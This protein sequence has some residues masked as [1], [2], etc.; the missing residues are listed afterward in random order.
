MRAWYKHGLPNAHIPGISS[1]LSRYITVLAQEWSVFLLIWL[2]L[3]HRGLSIGSLVRGRWQTLG[4]FFKDLGL[5]IGFLVVIVPLLAVLVHFIGG[6]TNSDVGNFTPKTI[7][8]LV[9]FL[10]LAATAGF[11]EEL[12]YRGYLIQQLHA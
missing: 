11:C 7:L 12:I 1:R 3:K 8:E 5:A 4:A 2:A 10:G 6:D 9:L